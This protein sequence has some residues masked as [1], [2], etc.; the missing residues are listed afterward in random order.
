MGPS[1]WQILICIIVIFLLFGAKKIPELA[2]SLGKT[3]SEFKR[4]IAE[5]E[6]ESVAAEA[7]KAEDAKPEPAKELV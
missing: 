6:K 7:E 3:K 2:K 5:G 1:H 4:G